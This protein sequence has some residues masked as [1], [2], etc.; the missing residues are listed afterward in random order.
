M[1][2]AR[3]DPAWN[4]LTPEQKET[5]VEWLFEQSLS[6]AGVLEHAG[7][8]H[9][10]VEQQIEEITRRLFGEPPPGMGAYVST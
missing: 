6:Y 8:V 5:V 1:S 2:K 9:D 7:K 4:G 3:C 10:L